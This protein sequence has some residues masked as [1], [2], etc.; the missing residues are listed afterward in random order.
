[1]HG[2]AQAWGFDPLASP[3]TGLQLELH[4]LKTSAAA[5][6]INGSSS[7]PFVLLSRTDTFAGVR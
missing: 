1:M 3:E 4:A 7:L 5:G 6:G 2:K